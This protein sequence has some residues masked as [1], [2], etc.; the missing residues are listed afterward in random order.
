[1]GDELSGRLGA[2]P[3]RE[4]LDGW[5]ASARAVLADPG[6]RP[7]FDAACYARAWNEVPVTLDGETAVIDRLVDDG[8]ALVIVDYKTH[9]RPDAAQLAERYRPQLAAYADAVKA[10]WPG[11]PVRAG[12]LLTA[13]RAW[14][15][16]I[17]A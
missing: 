1:L 7:Y 4:E 13:T 17:P 15:S 5:L 8:E 16:V 9:S 10:I 12:L 11:R 6:L 14:V 3:P 2:R